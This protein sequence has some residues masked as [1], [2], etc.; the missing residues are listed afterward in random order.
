MKRIS[1]VCDV[2]TRIVKAAIKHLERWFNEK[3]KPSNDRSL[4][5]QYWE[6]FITTI[7]GQPEAGDL[8]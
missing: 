2:P 1:L 4:R 5:F 6:V 8:L 7:V 3:T